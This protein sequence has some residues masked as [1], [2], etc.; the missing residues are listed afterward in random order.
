MA[1]VMFKQLKNLIKGCNK[2][3]VKNDANLKPFKATLLPLFKFIKDD[4]PSADSR[5]ENIEKI[6]K[7]FEG[8]IAKFRLEAFFKDAGFRA[9]FN[10]FF[11]TLKKKSYT[12][13][14]NRAYTKGQDKDICPI[15]PGYIAQKKAQYKEILKDY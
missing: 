11:K 15:I 9:L 6:L 1:K 13:T 12:P 8:D 5:P 3:V 7:L 14:P 4:Q 10:K 2:A